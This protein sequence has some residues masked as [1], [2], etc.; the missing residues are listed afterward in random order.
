MSIK[1]EIEITNKGLSLPT[2][3]NAPE[4]SMSVFLSLT[5]KA[6]INLKSEF[7]AAPEKQYI[8]RVSNLW[9]KRIILW[10]EQ[11][12]AWHR[13]KITHPPQGEAK[14]S[15]NMAKKNSFIFAEKTM[16]HSSTVGTRQYA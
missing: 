13:G 7:L 5:V 1:S 11:N 4:S 6:S 9:E 12:L 14:Y 15:N 8:L 16:L 10:P 3:L 2:S